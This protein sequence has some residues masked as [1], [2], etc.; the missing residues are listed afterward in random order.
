[1]TVLLIGD[2][3][4]GKS[5]FVDYLVS[6]E[7]LA[8][9]HPSETVQTHRIKT[10]HLGQ[11][12]LTNALLMEMSEYT[13][14]PEEGTACAIFFVSAINKSSFHPIRTWCDQVPARIPK[15]LMITYGDQFTQDRKYQHLAKYCQKK[16]F[17]ATY[18]CSTPD[19]LFREISAIDWEEMTSI[20]NA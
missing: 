17:L 10:F 9:Y 14:C 7:Y 1:M 2:R 8:E 3:R 12:H 13:M 18:I 4:T 20:T 6:G 11:I 16:N 15:I 19:G 5:T